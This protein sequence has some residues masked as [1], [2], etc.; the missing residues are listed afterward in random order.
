[1][2]IYFQYKHYESADEALSALNGGFYRGCFLTVDYAQDL[3][4]NGS[5]VEVELDGDIEP[6]AISVDNFASMEIAKNETEEVIVLQMSDASEAEAFLTQTRSPVIEVPLVSDNSSSPVLVETLAYVED[7]PPILAYASKGTE[8]EADSESGSVITLDSTSASSI[9]LLTEDSRLSRPEKTDVAAMVPK[10]SNSTQFFEQSNQKRDENMNTCM[11]GALPSGLDSSIGDIGVFP[12]S[13]TGFRCSEDEAMETLTSD[14]LFEPFL[15]FD[16]SIITSELEDAGVSVD[17][18]ISSDLEPVVIDLGSPLVRDVKCAITGTSMSA[19]QYDQY[20]NMVSAYFSDPSVSETTAATGSGLVS[21]RF[22][23]RD[24][25]IKSV[26]FSD[27]SDDPV[28]APLKHDTPEFVPKA[29]NSLESDTDG[30]SVTSSSYGKKGAKYTDPEDASEGG[31]GDDASSEAIKGEYS[32]HTGQ[33]ESD[34][35][36]IFVGNIGR[37][38]TDGVQLLTNYFKSLDIEVLK[39]DIKV[40]FAF[41][42]VLNTPTLDDQIKAISIKSG[43][44]PPPFG[45]DNRAF[46]IEFVQQ[47]S[48]GKHN[49]RCVSEFS[50][51]A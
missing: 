40:S 15:S 12:G 3:H 18:V 26:A 33:Y 30:L 23:V 16:P 25:S 22:V 17:A 10:C 39:V 35:R 32:V 14:S 37:L 24:S 46:R 19:A 5:V 42:E 29:L 2:F 36:N 7:S 20:I 27:L 47:T 41:L 4:G 28:V 11:G 31:D 6:S 34:I 45:K 49:I 1:M 8:D 43:G 50:R 9:T 13:S 44:N 38:P 48:A 51:L 21:G